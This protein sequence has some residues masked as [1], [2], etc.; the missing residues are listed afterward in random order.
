MEA[1]PIGPRFIGGEKRAS[2]RG[3]GRDCTLPDGA[4]SEATHPGPK[5]ENLLLDTF[6]QERG[7]GNSDTAYSLKITNVPLHMISHIGSYLQ[8]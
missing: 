7:D 3:A 6:S 4:N 2:Q 1:L 5:I 8:N